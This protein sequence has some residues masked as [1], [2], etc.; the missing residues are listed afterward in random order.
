MT[1]RKGDWM[2]TASGHKF[3]PL[4][5]KPAEVFIDDIAHALSNICRYSGH[6]RYF[7]SVA[8]HSILVSR[9]VRK[10]GGG[11]FEVRQGLLHDAAEA[12]LGD[13]IRPLKRC[14]PEYK[15]AEELV[16]EAIMV[17]FDMPVNLYTAV[18]EADEI[19][20]ATEAHQLMPAKSV[21]EW[22]LPGLPD[23]EVTVK[24]MRPT[25]AKR[26]FLAEFHKIW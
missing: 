7:Y 10:L 20:L 15:K 5:P 1:D 2:C 26:A 18:K 21:A 23:L 24:C 17:R 3:W 11:V 25:E 4:D 13:M 9:Q 12:Y 22:N 19:L 14:L 6:C 16:H 8:E